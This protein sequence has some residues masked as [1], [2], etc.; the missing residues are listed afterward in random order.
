MRDLTFPFKTVMTA[1][2]TAFAILVFVMTYFTVAQY[3]QAVITSWGKF[4]YVAGPGLHFKVPFRDEA[5]FYRTDIQKITV[6]KRSALNTYT[7]DNQEVDVIPT[8]FFRIPVD[9]VGF[10]YENAR[11]YEPLLMKMVE[12]R[13]KAEMGKIN[14]EGL[15]K[16]RGKIRDA[17]KVT[18]VNDALVLGLAVTDF[19]LNELTYTKSFRTTVEGAAMAKATVETKEQ[20]RLQAIKVAQTAK[21][22]AEGVANGVREAAKGEADAIWV[23]AQAE[24]RSIQA[25][26]E[27]EAKAIRAQAEALQQNQKLVE[28]RKAERW[29]GKLPTQMLSNVLPIMNFK[30]PTDK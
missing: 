24:A 21:I 15:A 3:E 6:D 7:E 19:Q 4:N 20:E 9:K 27:A 26:G 16:H 1:I 28:L 23:K 18:L 25:R 29:D 30:S 22:R 14:V 2:G 8:T 11:D 17:I 5:H 13:L 12:D 10:V